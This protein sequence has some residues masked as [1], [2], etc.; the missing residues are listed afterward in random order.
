MSDE[1][2]KPDNRV[3]IE[4][5]ENKLSDKELLKNGIVKDELVTIAT[6]QRIPIEVAVEVYECKG[7][8]PDKSFLNRIE[9][10]AG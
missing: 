8:I 2:I 10:N 4:S 9:T 5:Y 6:N 1:R 7:A 3:N